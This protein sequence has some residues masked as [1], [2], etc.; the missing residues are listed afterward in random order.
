MKTKISETMTFFYGLPDGV[1]KWKDTFDNFKNP[2]SFRNA[3]FIDAT[4]CEDGRGD[5]QAFKGVDIAL[6]LLH[7]NPEIVVILF[8]FAPAKLVAKQN[9][10]FNVV[11][12]H[13]NV[14]FLQ[15]PMNPATLEEDIKKAWENRPVTDP[16]ATVQYATYQA[17]VLMHGIKFDFLNPKSDQERSE[18][19]KVAEQGRKIFKSKAGAS[20]SEVL[21]FMDQLR[22]NREEVAKGKESPGVFC[23]IEGT[24][25]VDGQINSKVA[26]LLN[27]FSKGGK[28]V[29]L[30]TDGDMEILAPI[31]HNL[32]VRYPILRKMD[33]AGSVVE[34]AIDDLDQYTFSGLTKIG[35][36][37]FIQE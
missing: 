14:I 32:G 4:Y 25:L 15:L 3:V 20:D 1:Q 2:G 7:A 10:K 35:T 17:S 33:F 31:L 37:K 21:E 18:M 19:G 27:E 22:H 29:F 36:K 5:L 9:D 34:I 11:L 12:R 16:S 24:I 8:T 13:D 30:W 23:D 6:R 28:S 26:N